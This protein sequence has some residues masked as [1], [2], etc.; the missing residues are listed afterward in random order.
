M[1][2]VNIINPRYLTDQHLIAEYL[3][4]IMLVEYVKKH[5]KTSL[6]KIPKRYLLGPGHILFFKN[7]LNYLKKRHKQIKEEMI[8]RGFN[9]IRKLNFS[10]IN[11]SLIKSWK[12]RPKDKQIIKERIIER[13][14]RKPDWYKYYRKKRPIK[15]LVDL[16]KNAT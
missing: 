16:I 5:P 1:V 9:P 8:K 10:G 6:N 4:I 12:P 3:E 2:R 7:K 14:N 11:K 13:I 15:F